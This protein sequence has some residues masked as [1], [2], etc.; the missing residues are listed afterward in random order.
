EFMT[1]LPI[2][3]L[4]FAP[5]AFWLWYFYHRD[6]L[7]PEPQSL[8]IRTF[9]FGLLIAIPAAIVEVAFSWLF[10]ALGQVVLIAV[11]APVVEEYA[12]Y[13]CVRRTIYRDAEFDEPMDG[14]VYAAAA[15]LGFASIEN[16]GYLLFAIREGGWTGLEIAFILRALLSVPGHVLF[17]SIWGGAL[18]RAKFMQDAASANRLI[19]N[20]LF[21]AMALHGLFNFL[22]SFELTG[23]ELLAVLGAI[24]LLILVVLAWV[25]IH[26]RMSEALLD[27]PYNPSNMTRQ[28]PSSPSHQ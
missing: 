21:G 9:F 20:G 3:L 24:G 19:R 5:G 22:A 15:A 25:R 10:A 1:I 11:I 4:G 12:K 2:L 13:L 17:S 6:K 16:V 8:V 18:G 23:N 27:S 14:I 7:E 26:R 28:E